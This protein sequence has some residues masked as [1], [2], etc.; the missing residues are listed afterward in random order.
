MEFPRTN[1]EVQINEQLAAR[2]V[3]HTLHLEPDGEIINLDYD[4]IKL[5]TIL[6]QANGDQLDEKFHSE[7]IKVL[8]SYITLR[9]R[10]FKIARTPTLNNEH[11]LKIGRIFQKY[12]ITDQIHGERHMTKAIT[13]PRLMLLFPHLLAKIVTIDLNVESI[14]P[15]RVLQDN[16]LS[17]SSP[18]CFWKSS[19]C[20][21]PKFQTDVE[22][23]DRHIKII[24]AMLL[25][26]YE[27]H[28]VIHEENQFRVRKSPVE[29]MQAT[30]MNCKVIY[31][32]NHILGG[33]RW[34]S[35]KS[36]FLNDPLGNG[37]KF[38]Y[39]KAAEVFDTKFFELNSV[40]E[41]I[42]RLRDGTGIENGTNVNEIL[43]VIEK[44]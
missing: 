15:H 10:V 31:N 1:R 19:F 28:E 25:T 41:S 14:I 9:K 38:E 7:I 22:D 36:F 27:Q 26:Q 3:N 34:A 4:P 12:H 32:S 5:Y 6:K 11:F 13:M 18:V 2:Y 8:Q 16:G 29:R 35:Y 39:E 43:S 42:F 23:P 37:V 24:K 21:L 20:L 33:I 30:L 44:L 17:S 40:L